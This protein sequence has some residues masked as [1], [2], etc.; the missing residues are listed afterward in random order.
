MY[1]DDKICMAEE[2]FLKLKGKKHKHPRLRIFGFTI[3]GLITVT[4]VMSWIIGLGVYGNWQDAT[5]FLGFSIIAGLATLIYAIPFFVGLGFLSTGIWQTS[6]YNWA[7]SVVSLTGTGLTELYF[8]LWA[9]GMVTF[10]LFVTMGIFMRKVV[11][12]W[13]TKE[14]E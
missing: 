10:G 4:M 6:Q 12:K 7:L 8:W 5:K 1:E 11:I 3:V 2:D 13:R 14:R 9:I